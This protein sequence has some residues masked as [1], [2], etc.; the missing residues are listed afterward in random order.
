M[1]AVNFRHTAD[2]RVAYFP[3]GLLGPGYV[4]PTRPVFEK[5]YSIANR[6]SI[7]AWI[8]V[9]L[10]LL[11]SPSTIVTFPVFAVLY[12]IFVPR[13][14]S[15]LTPVSDSEAISGIWGNQA[16]RTRICVSVLIQLGC[17]IL[18]AVGVVALFIPSHMQTGLWLMCVFGPVFAGL[19][20][21][22]VFNLR[23]RRMPANTPLNPTVAKNAPAG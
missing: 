3:H 11:W 20:Q 2:N 5:A 9:L 16:I 10:G 12:L 7:S 23:V 18:I 8:L 19:F 14:V 22:T 1:G 6:F 4:L 13:L 17:L 21:A 15:G